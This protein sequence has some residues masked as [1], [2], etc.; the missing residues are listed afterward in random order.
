MSPAEKKS[1]LSTR[2]RSLQGQRRACSTFWRTTSVVD[3]H[4]HDGARRALYRWQG[5]GDSNKLFGGCDSRLAPGPVLFTPERFIAERRN[6]L[7]QARAK[8]MRKAHAPNKQYRL[9]RRPLTDGKIVEMND[10][11]DPS[12][13]TLGARH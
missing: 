2:K 7:M 6:G 13:I 8:A 12:L 9:H 11:I 3:D 1:L 4:R 5:R 10:Y